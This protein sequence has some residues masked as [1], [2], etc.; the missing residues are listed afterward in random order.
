MRTL[1]L[2][3]LAG[4]MEVASAF[5]SAGSGFASL[6]TG[7]ITS[8]SSCLPSSRGGL[9]GLNMAHFVNNKGAKES[10]KNRPRKARL[11]DINRKAPEYVVDTMAAARQKMPEYTKTGEADMSS[12][13]KIEGEDGKVFYTTK[14]PY[15]AE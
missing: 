3:C 5:S 15:A 2:L 1:T 7:S 9:T 13:F 4:A 6:R 14:A 12:F 10:R 11:S 8:E